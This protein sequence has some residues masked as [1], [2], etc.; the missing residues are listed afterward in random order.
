MD[1][2]QAAVFLAG[3]ILTMLGFIVVIGGVIVINNLLNKFWKPIR[4]LRFDHY[5][6]H[7]PEQDVTEPTLKET[8]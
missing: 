5:P 3:S 1:M 2:N 7:Y 6:P 8:K 4:F